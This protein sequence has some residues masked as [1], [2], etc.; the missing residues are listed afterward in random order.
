VI[1]VREAPLPASLAT[2]IINTLTFNSPFRL[3]S[4]G[5]GLPVLLGLG[6]A[7]TVAGSYL[8]RSAYHAL[9]SQFTY[10]LS[11]RKED[12]LVTSFPYNIIRHPAYTGGNLVV[13]GPALSL[14]SPDGWLRICLLPFI[15][16][17]QA[18]MLVRTLVAVTCAATVFCWGTT[19][20]ATISRVKKEDGMMHKQFGQE[21]E[22]WAA[23][24]HFRIVPGVY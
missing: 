19:I 11:S 16:S 22:R 17:P 6:C 23:R 21:W 13:F 20:V 5:R 4:L 12:R 3:S 18:G 2:T 7:A 9:G 14:S 24:V 1:L 10:E 8:R 15:L